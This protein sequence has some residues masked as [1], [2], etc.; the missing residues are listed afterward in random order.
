[1]TKYPPGENTP[2]GIRTAGQPCPRRKLAALGIAV[3][4]ST[5]WQIIKDAGIGP[6]PRRDGPG[7]AEFL[8]SQT[9]GI[10]AMDFCTAD[11]LNGTKVYVLAVIEHGNRRVRVPG[12]TE[13]PVQSWAVQQARNLLMDFARYAS[14]YAWDFAGIW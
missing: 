7:W 2:R 3:A 9:Q 14:A 8:R 11:L 12:A 13:H 1:L 10:P 5:V 4:P 6:A